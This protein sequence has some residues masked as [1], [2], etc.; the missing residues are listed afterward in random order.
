MKKIL[1]LLIVFFMSVSHVNAQ[2]LYVDGVVSVPEKGEANIV[3]K[4]ESGGKDITGYGFTINL[5]KGLSFVFE[6]GS[7][8]M[9]YVDG[10]GFLATYQNGNFGF[11]PQSPG[12]K[13]SGGTG[14]LLILTI[15][16][17][18][19]LKAGE[20][21][22]IDITDASFTDEQL[23]E[24]SVPNSTFTVKIIENR[25]VLDETST[26]VPE[27]AENVNVLVKRTIKSDKWNTICLPFAMSDDQ[28]KAAFGEGV[29]LADFDGCEFDGDKDNPST[30]IHVKFVT[31]SA[32]EANHPYLIKISDLISEFRVDNVTISAEDNPGINKDVVSYKVG[33][34]TYYKYNSFLGTYVPTSVPKGALYINSNKFYY[35]T[36]GSTIKGFRGYFDFQV[37]W[38][39][40]QPYD[41]KIDILVDGDATSVEGFNV[42]HVVDGIYDLSGRKIQLEGNDLNKL[43][44]G[45]YIIDG[46]KVTI[47]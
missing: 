32:I 10:K 26:T 8:K 25:I 18:E 35:S 21:F 28:V 23:A 42:Q 20:S 11:L 37:S 40:E 13:V 39:E 15:E 43:Q 19:T 7:I 41:A 46:K 44:K 45:V 16:A 2:R 36:G 3:L 38:L 30:F 29:Q 6:N 34:D 17:D 5:P 22:D 9:T 12:N 33:R 24:V 27:A 1:F 4:Y 47:K 14:E 31:A